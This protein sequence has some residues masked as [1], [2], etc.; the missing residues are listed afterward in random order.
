MKIERAR[1]ASR[2]VFFGVILKINQTLM[3]FLMRTAIIYLMGVQYLGLNSLF[4]SILQVLNLAELGVGSAMVF[5]IYEPIAN[6]D[7]TKIRALVRLYK[8]YYRGIGFVIAG[9]GIVIIPFIP[10]LISGDIPSD[11]NIYVFYLLNLGATVLSYWLFSYKNSLLQAYQRTD[12]ISKISIIIDTFRYGSQLLVLWIFKDYYLYVIALL[13][14]QIVSNIVS[15]VVVTKMFPDYYPEGKLPQEEVKIINHHI[16]DLFTAKLGAVIVGSADTIV[17]SAFLGLVILAVYQNYYFVLTSI[18]AFVEVIFS[19]CTA[20]IGNSL[21]VESKEKNFSDLKKFTF[22]IAWVSGVC[23]CC[24]LNLYQPFMKIWVGEGLMLDYTAV[25]CFVIYFYVYEINRILNTYKDAG[26]V[27]HQD[28]FRP[29]VTAM[30]NLGMNLIM[31]QFWG[32]YGVLF[33]TVLSTVFIG[34]PWILHNL[35]TTLFDKRFL[36]EYLK[37]LFVYILMS[38]LVA[39]LS[40]LICNF[41]NMNLWLTI[42]LRLFVCLIIPN[43]IFIFAYHRKKEFSQSIN[44]INNITKGKLSRFL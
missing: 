41:I 38:L 11:I 12:I 28:R 1:N 15:A 3:P 44:L 37:S 39:I 9:L 32:I 24:F 20:G 40:V 35:F 18:I 2:N 36:R 21:I 8:L 17:I 30:A 14:S 34:M 7:V 6:D 27:W 4:T 43:V 33:S 22:L 26:G 29:L 23:S 42:F 13:V 19:A 16:K 31:V 25:I 10:K 5:S